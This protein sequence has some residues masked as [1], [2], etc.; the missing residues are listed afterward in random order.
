[1]QV[2]ALQQKPVFF[3]RSCSSACKP[4]GRV[5]NSDPLYNHSVGLGR[6]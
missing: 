6:F 1:M 4:A 5:Q 2:A 3:W